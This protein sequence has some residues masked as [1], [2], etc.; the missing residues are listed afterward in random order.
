[1]IEESVI[2]GDSS[3]DFREYAD[4]AN[5]WPK[6]IIKK[7]S[8]LSRNNRPNLA[9]LYCRL[10]IPVTGNIKFFQIMGNGTETQFVQA[11]H[12]TESFVHYRD[13]FYALAES[14]EIVFEYSLSYITIIYK[15]ITLPFQ[16]IKKIYLHPDYVSCLQHIRIKNTSPQN[17]EIF[18][19][20]KAV[21][22]LGDPFHTTYTAF[23]KD[24]YSGLKV[25]N[26][27]SRSYTGRFLMSGPDVT[28]IF[29][30]ND[31]L[32]HQMKIIRAPWKHNQNVYKNCDD[33]SGLLQKK[34]KIS[35]GGADNNFIICYSAG[36]ASNEAAH[37]TA[38]IFAAFQKDSLNDLET[39]LQKR[40]IEFDMVSI[41]DRL[42]SFSHHVVVAYYAGLPC[43]FQRFPQT[44]QFQQTK[45]PVLP[46]NSLADHAL[47]RHLQ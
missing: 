45:F 10:D 15:N 26:E 30:R 36:G 16:V 3:T 31:Q 17:F 35:S 43:F 41:P 47:Q 22:T 4:S 39:S 34:L 25:G 12:A 2:A 21:F 28:R 44:A 29:T 5:A 24:N 23:A 6:I 1:M 37:G 13:Q 7:D 40:A 18:F 9:N 27:L 14:D 33:Q 19:L 46:G 38:E 32:Q 8:K 42:P 11:V 20:E